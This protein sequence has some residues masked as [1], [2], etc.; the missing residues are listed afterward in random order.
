MKSRPDREG[1]RQRIAV[2]SALAEI[3]RKLEQLQ[4]SAEARKAC[5]EVGARL[6]EILAGERA[7]TRA[8]GS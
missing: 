2:W 8:K 7:A 1:R 3:C 5:R 4:A 6:A